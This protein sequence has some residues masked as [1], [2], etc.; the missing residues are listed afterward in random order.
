MVDGVYMPTSSGGVDSVTH[1]L[2]I[3]LLGVL[4]N[5]YQTSAG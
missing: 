1:S 5:N 2:L 4:G 3:C